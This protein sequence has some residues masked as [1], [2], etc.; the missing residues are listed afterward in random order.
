MAI[1]IYPEFCLRQLDD[2]RAILARGHT[3]QSRWE[4]GVEMMGMLNVT[5]VGEPGLSF[6][7]C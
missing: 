4:A 3:S 6:N 5:G 1:R 2:G 7:W